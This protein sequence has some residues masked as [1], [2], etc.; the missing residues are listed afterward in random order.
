MLTNLKKFCIAHGTKYSFFV[1]EAIRAKLEDEELREDIMDLKKL[2]K[3]EVNAF[4]F[5]D[6]LRHRNV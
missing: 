1:E 5:E 4:S 6:Y 2:K 3:E